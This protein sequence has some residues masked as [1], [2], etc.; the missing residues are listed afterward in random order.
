MTNIT[1]TVVARYKRHCLVEGPAGQRVSCQLQRRSLKPVVGDAVIWHAESDETT[2]TL[3][4]ISPRRSELTRIDS[5]GRPELIAANISQ[6]VI[7]VAVDP[8]PDWFLLDRYLAAAELGPFAALIVFNKVDLA[9]EIP[10]E[11]AEYSGLGYASCQ[12]SAARHKGLDKLAT[13]MR[14]NRSVMIGQSGVGKS[15][16]LNALVG[17]ALQTVGELSEKSGQ[18]RH[19]T[20]TAV[21]YSVPGGGELIDS[22]GVRDYAPYIADSRVVANG[23]REF[24]PLLS[25]C[26]FQDCRH[27]AEPNC[28]IKHA[29]MTGQLAQRRYASYRRLYEL[30]ESLQAGKY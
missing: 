3:T 8:A 11:L 1:G 16:L 7:V 29:V 18:G 9:V 14:G 28:A 4:E 30:T 15:S 17:D 10:P 24:V 25:E 27:L 20:S 19:T 26:R 13:E 2:G 21:L 22:P 12:T 23:F 6:L 5:R